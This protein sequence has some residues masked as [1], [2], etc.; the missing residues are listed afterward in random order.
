MVGCHP[1]VE[2]PESD[3]Q[4]SLVIAE[5]FDVVREIGYINRHPEQL[6]SE[7]LPMNLSFARCHLR[8]RNAPFPLTPTLSRGERENGLPIWNLPNRFWIVL[9]RAVWFPLPWGEGEGEGKQEVSKPDARN[10][11]SVR[12][13]KREIFRGLEIGQVVDRSGESEAV[14]GMERN[15]FRAPRDRLV[16]HF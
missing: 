4:L 3:F 13:S 10:H 16:R 14:E 5:E 8:L 7:S 1:D 9:K 11:T 6:T 2:L 12:G 15:K